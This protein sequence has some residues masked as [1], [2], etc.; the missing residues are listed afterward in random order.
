MNGI[1]IKLIIKAR[2]AVNA[3]ILPC[4]PVYEI[5]RSSHPNSAHSRFITIGKP[6]ARVQNITFLT[7]I[8]KSTDRT[9]K[10]GIVFRSDDERPICCIL[11]VNAVGRDE[12]VDA[13]GFATTPASRCFV[14]LGFWH[15][16]T[17]I[18][19][20]RDILGIGIINTDIVIGRSIKIEQTEI[21]P[22]PTN[23]VFALGISRKRVVKTSRVL[24][25]VLRPVPHS[26][27]I[28]IFDNNGT[29]TRLTFPGA[30]EGETRF[31]WDGRVL[32]NTH[33]FEAVDEMVIDKKLALVGCDKWLWQIHR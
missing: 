20:N 15:A 22:L 12:T 18:H 17:F 9:I 13:S 31:A 23:A 11:P 3:D 28:A 30:V 26:V 27:F 5:R 6:A 21:G 24:L 19:K 8:P 7:C 1:C 29:P 33:I 2:F 14:P 32:V 10:I 16:G 25:F 4:V